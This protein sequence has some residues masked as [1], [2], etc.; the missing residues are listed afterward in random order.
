[1]RVKYLRLTHHRTAL[2]Q[3]IAASIKEIRPILKTWRL[4]LDLQAYLTQLLN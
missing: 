1:M 3:Q 4:N 2:I